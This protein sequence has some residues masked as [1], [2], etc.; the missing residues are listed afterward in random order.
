MLR[1][2]PGEKEEHHWSLRSGKSL[3][4]QVSDFLYFVQEVTTGSSP[5]SSLA[6]QGKQEDTIT[7]CLP[8]V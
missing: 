7:S 3:H 1:P 2:A 4:F 5:L 8:H 6:N